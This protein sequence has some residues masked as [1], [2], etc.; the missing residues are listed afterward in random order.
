MSRAA[1]YDQIAT[2][3]DQIRDTGL[4]KPE[5]LITSPQGGRVQVDGAGEVLNFCANNYLG[6]ADHPDIVKAAQDTM[7]DYGFGMA[8]V[9]FICGTTDLHR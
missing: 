3:L 4:W 7:N 9:R 2:T 6:L 1:F 5:R 8:S